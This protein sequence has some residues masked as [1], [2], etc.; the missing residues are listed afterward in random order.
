MKRLSLPYRQPAADVVRADE[1]V[2]V[3][4][5]EQVP[6][7]SHLP[8][9]DY[10][11][12]LHLRRTV[13]IDADALRTGAALP[14]SAPI[15]LAVV[16][17]ASGSG[18]RAAA[19][20][21][22]LKA[23]ESESIDLE[24]LIAGADLGGLLALETVIVLDERMV[25]AAPVAARRAG[26]VLWR[27]RREL[28]LQGDAPQFPLA[29]VDFERTSF[30][31]DAAWHLQIS[32]NLSAATMGA[33]LLL[34]NERNPVALSA[35][36]NAAKPRP[37]DKVVLSTIYMDVARTMVEHALRSEEFSETSEYDDE[38][39]GATLLALVEQLFPGSSISDLRLRME[40]APAHFASEIQAAVKVF[41]DS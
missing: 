37:V 36:Q 39:L 14:L 6:L 9:W 15:S 2:I 33:M 23:T 10:R 28:R 18:L 25:D 11:T 19:C 1:W 38:T 32:Q 34:I 17:N 41:G 16:W 29:V 30:P 7:P 8:D 31:N 27:E 13:Q 12:N 40:S 4:D 21:I 5:D 35:F 26:S 22:P 3:M 20:R 24:V